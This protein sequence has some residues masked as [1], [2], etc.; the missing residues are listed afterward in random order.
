[1]HFQTALSQMAFSFYYFREQNKRTCHFT[2]AAVHSHLRFRSLSF[3]LSSEFIKIYVHEHIGL[4]LRIF[5][6]ACA[7]IPAAFSLR[8]EPD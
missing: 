5:T 3:F 6:M 1:M 4:T 8:W 2:D 7:A